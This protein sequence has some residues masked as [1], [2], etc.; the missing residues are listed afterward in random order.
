M[1][2]IVGLPTCHE[3]SV[4]YAHFLAL[5]H[6]YMVV[7]VAHMFVEHI[8]KLHGMSF[9]IV[10]DRDPLFLSIF[11]KEVFKLQSSKLCMSSGY[12]HQSDGQTEVVNKCLETYLRCFVE[13]KPKSWVKWLPWA[14]RNYSTLYHIASKFTPF[15][16]VYGYPPP[17]VTAYEFGAAKVNI[18]EHELWERDHLLTV[19][20]NNLAMAQNQMKVQ[21]NKNR[22]ERKFEVG[23]Y[24]YL[25][26]LPYQL[27]P[28]ASHSYHKLHPRYYRPYE[29]LER[30]GPVAYKLKLPERTKIHLVFHVCCLKKHVGNRDL[31]AA[32]LPIITKDGKVQD[33]PLALL[34]RRMY[35]K[36]DKAGVQLLIQWVGQEKN[37]V[38][39]EDYDDYHSQ[40]LEFQF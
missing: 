35:K 17:H 2:F 36:E 18:V 26:L 3:K 25:R 39:W 37:I 27:Q 23:D 8:F 14:E 31:Q 28:L 11:W 21:A 13:N 1:D 4:K 19:L 38:T 33:A 40:F 34:A 5:A 9:T 24:V 32:T 15:E 6:P 20:K 12:H 7:S 10:S 16:L 22:T 29:V 30:I